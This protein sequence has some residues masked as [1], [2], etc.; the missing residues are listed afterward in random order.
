MN[1]NLDALGSRTMH[2]D[3]VAEQD[4]AEGLDQRSEGQRH[5]KLMRLATWVDLNSRLSVSSI[6]SSVLDSL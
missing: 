6:Y 2:F 5:G 1:L 4:V 3:T